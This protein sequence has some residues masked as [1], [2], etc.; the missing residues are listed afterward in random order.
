LR[1]NRFADNGSTRIAY[2]LC[3]RIDRRKSWLV[4]IQGLGFDRSGWAPVVSALRRRFRLV[5]IDNR[6]SGRSTTPDRKFT[7]A[8]MAA[9]VAAV[10]DSSRIARAH[11]LGASLGGMVAQELAIR[12]PQRVDRLVLACTTPGWPYGY[13][14]PRASVQRMTAAASLP[15]EAAQRSLVENALAPDTLK[16]HPEL[17]ERIVRNQKVTLGDPASWKALANAGATYSGGTRQSLI[18]ALTLIMYGDADAVVD[19]RN[20]KLLSGRIPSSQVVVFPGLGHLFF[21]EEPAQFAKAVTSFLL[22]PA[23]KALNSSDEGQSHSTRSHN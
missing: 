4:L 23:E 8:D 1:S 19:P 21:W 15:A 7:M 9:D 2:E 10:L 14:M 17:V 5:L 6:G 18:R 22:A 20:S 11:V 12:H 3:G 13:P 16:E